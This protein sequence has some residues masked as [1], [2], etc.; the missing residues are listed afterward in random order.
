MA[1]EHV[2]SAIG[3]VE[4]P[5]GVMW[6]M[7][8]TIID[9]E[10]EWAH[11]SRVVVERHGGEWTADDDAY[12][13]GAST[14]D[15]AARLAS[16]VFVTTGERLGASD[17]FDEMS[18]LLA[19]EVFA[20]VEPLPGAAELLRA[21]GE[22]RIAQALVTATPMNLVEPV[23][24]ALEP[25]RFDSVVT[26]SDDIPGKPNPAPYL[27]GAERLGVAAENCV[28]F[29]DSKPGLAAARASG[30][31]TID[32]GQYPLADLAKLL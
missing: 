15:H 30:A 10:S 11:Y 18:E 21:V 22:A 17:L 25:I 5:A 27:L 32:V 26:G 6:D 24:G 3:L 2:F 12:I 31:T 9:T 4:P 1:L 29:E 13:N 28:A 16:A 7:D 19:T 20:N 23:L 14:E 8:G